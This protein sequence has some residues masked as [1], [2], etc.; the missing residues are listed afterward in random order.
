MIEN[1]CELLNIRKNFRRVEPHMD[2]DA[3]S[4][5]LKKSEFHLIYKFMSILLMDV[6][7]L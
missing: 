3:I 1:Q 5:A 2:L 7:N 6:N 4:R